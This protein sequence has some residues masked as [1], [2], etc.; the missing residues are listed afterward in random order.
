MC[1][2]NGLFNDTKVIMATIQ[3]LNICSYSIF[4]YFLFRNEQEKTTFI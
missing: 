1:I 4:D 2:K 3:K